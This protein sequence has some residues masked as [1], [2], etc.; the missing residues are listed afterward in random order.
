M[1]ESDDGGTRVDDVLAPV[2]QPTTGGDY[3]PHRD[4]ERVRGRLAFALVGLLALV[5]AALFFAVIAGWRTWDELQGLATL[6]FAPLISLTG[7]MLGFYY[8][9]L[10]R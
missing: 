1:S 8:G 9:Q 10:E 2:P 3:N 6:T 4:R 5:A 7:T